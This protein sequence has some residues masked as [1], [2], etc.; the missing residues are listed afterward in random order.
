MSWRSGWLPRT[1]RKK[2]KSV[3]IVK[4]KNIWLKIIGSQRLER[5]YRRNNRYKENLG[6]RF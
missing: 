4:L 5:D 3:I 6:S 1:P 2:Y